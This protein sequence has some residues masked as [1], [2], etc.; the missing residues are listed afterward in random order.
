M[1]FLRSNSAQERFLSPIKRA[2][3]PTN[4]NS[5]LPRISVCLYSPECSSCQRGHGM[6]ANGPSAK[7]HLTI[8]FTKA[9]TQFIQDIKTALQV[10]GLTI[11]VGLT[12]VAPSPGYFSITTF[13]SQWTTSGITI[14]ASLDSSNK[15]QG[16]NQ[17]SASNNLSSNTY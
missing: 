17:N 14:A 5:R 8:T 16:A 4:R 7:Y 13:R 10:L 3:F 9:Q 15:S 11:P 1:V 12:P 6:G 2:G